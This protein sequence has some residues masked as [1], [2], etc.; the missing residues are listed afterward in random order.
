MAQKLSK[1]FTIDEMISSITATNHKIDNT[2]PTDVVDK[3]S[4]LC[5][6]VLDPAREVFGKPIHVNSGYRCKELNR[7][8]GGKAN[9]YHLNGQ[10]ADLHVDNAAEGAYLSALL[11]SAEKCDLVILERRGK[12]YW[13]HVQWSMAP[14]HRYIQDFD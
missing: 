2:P 9:S 7:L 5:N 4:I 6:E 1:Y 3:L 8:V 11:L 13:V 12:K 10:A 14:R